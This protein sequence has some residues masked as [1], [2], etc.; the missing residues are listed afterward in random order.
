M[1]SVPLLDLLHTLNY[2]VHRLGLD[3]PCSFRRVKKLHASLSRDAQFVEYF[4]AEDVEVNPAHQV[5]LANFLDSKQV[6]ICMVRSQLSD[7]IEG[8]FILGIRPLWFDIFI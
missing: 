6:L 8:A 5:S 1:D 3:Y 2:A 4:T 7:I